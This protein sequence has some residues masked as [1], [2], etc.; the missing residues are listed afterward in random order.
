VHDRERQLHREVAL[1]LGSALPD[2]EVLAVELAGRE[3]LCVYIHHPD[4]VDHAL[5]ARVTKFLGHYLRDYSLEVSSPGSEPPLRTPAH[6][7]GALG[8]RVAVRTTE[9]VAGR[10]KF[11][12]EVVAADDRAFTLVAGT[13][14]RVDVPYE[15][16]ARSNLIDEGR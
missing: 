12:G 5:C 14:E 3:R 9:Q 16:V 4:G 1:E 15:A 2:V 10:T 13:G 6:F 7:A 8:R 11:K